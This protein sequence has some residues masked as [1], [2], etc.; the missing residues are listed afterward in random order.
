MRRLVFTLVLAVTTLVTADF[1]VA[2]SNNAG[3]KAT[4]AVVAQPVADNAQANPYSFDRQLH[5]KLEFA[6][7]YPATSWICQTLRSGAPWWRL[8]SSETRASRNLQRARRGLR[9]MMMAGH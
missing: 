7:W 3:G 6:Q 9:T 8:T 4:V 2:G 5:P 1:A